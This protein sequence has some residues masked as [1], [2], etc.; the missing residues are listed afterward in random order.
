MDITM[1]NVK[2]LFAVAPKAVRAKC[3]FIPQKN[4]GATLGLGMNSLCKFASIS[5]W[6]S[7]IPSPV[8]P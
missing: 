8:R 2:L 3:C 5:A 1:Q 4:P 6:L 7:F